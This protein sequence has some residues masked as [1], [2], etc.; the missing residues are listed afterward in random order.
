MAEEF[1]SKWQEKILAL[2][3]TKTAVN[4]SIVEAKEDLVEF[5]EKRTGPHLFV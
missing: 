3:K 1:K 4:A 5:P 2:A